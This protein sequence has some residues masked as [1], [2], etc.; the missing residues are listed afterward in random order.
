MPAPAGLTLLSAD[1]V[2]VT[3]AQQVLI[4]VAMGFALQLVFD[5]LTLGGQLLA[6]GMGLGFAFNV[7]PLRGVEHA[8]ARAV[9][10]ACSAR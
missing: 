7:D 10:R 2:L 9:V 6:N 1:G 4:G 3:T 5:A 8:G